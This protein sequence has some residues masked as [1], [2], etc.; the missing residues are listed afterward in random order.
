MFFIRSPI[1]FQLGNPRPS[2]ASHLVHVGKN[3][4][5]K[6]WSIWSPKFHLPLPLNEWFHGSPLASMVIQF[7]KKAWIVRQHNSWQKQG[8]IIVN[9]NIWNLYNHILGTISALM[10]A[11]IDEFRT[12]ETDY[13]NSKGFHTRHFHWM[14]SWKAT[15][16][17]ISSMVLQ[18]FLIW[19]TILQ[20]FMV[21]TPFLTMVFQWFCSTA[22]V[23]HDGFSMVSKGS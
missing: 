1:W 17:I 23:G 12:L 19:Q 13:P 15:I 6:H 2:A 7:H 8:Q 4:V 10:D 20:W 21:L 14:N 16:D 18:W 22:T 11:H 3:T 9:T 5:Q